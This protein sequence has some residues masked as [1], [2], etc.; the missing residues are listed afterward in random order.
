MSNRTIM[1]I[2]AQLCILFIA[3]SICEAVDEIYG[4]YKLENGQL[5]IV[6]NLT[7]CLPSEGPITFIGDVTAAREVN[8]NCKDG[9][10]VADAFTQAPASGRFTINIIGICQ[11]SVTI[12]RDD[13]TL[14]GASPG[15]GLQLPSGTGIVLHIAGARRIYLKQLT[16]KGGDQGLWVLGGSPFSASDL[17]ISGAASVGLH[18]EA[19]ASGFISNSIIENNGE[20]GIDASQG[21]TLRIFGGL[22]DNHS[23]YGISASG[24]AVSLHN[25]V[26]VKRVNF[27][28][29]EASSGGSI[30]IDDAIVE[31][32][33]IGGVAMDGGIITVGGS[34]TIIRAN[35]RGLTAQGG[36]S[37][38]V[39]DGVT[40]AEN[41]SM[42]VGG[43]FGAHISIGDAIIENNTG[44]GVELY[45]SAGSLGGGAIIRGNGGN[46]V[47]V[48]SGAVKI[49]HDVSITN[50]AGWGVICFHPFAMA[51][52]DDNATI[53]DNTEG[54]IN[55]PLN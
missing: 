9:E 29:L 53:E 19:N 3:W 24:G 48:W 8:V 4:C 15:D 30:D 16:L 37:I 50:N 51:D 23:H 6:D 17:H 18:L 38:T 13:V 20:I 25:G 55:C 12:K 11:E 27:M 31:N 21:G 14:R 22:I 44:N 33:K 47:N 42:G 41:S 26:V 36:G 1:A 40:I 54:A 28:A 49:H 10:T 5:R 35:E 46:G 32:N 52:V 39:G 45:S 34:G 7:E 2:L 43:W